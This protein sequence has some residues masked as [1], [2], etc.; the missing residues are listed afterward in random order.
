MAGCAWCVAWQ[1]VYM[2]GGMAMG[3]L[4]TTST[5]CV[6]LVLQIAPANMIS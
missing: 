2:A 5:S 3:V 4:N 6:L 1:A